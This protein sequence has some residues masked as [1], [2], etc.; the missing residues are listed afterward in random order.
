M[1]ELSCPTRE[2]IVTVSD[3]DAELEPHPEVTIVHVV[4]FRELRIKQMK[5][6]LQ[7]LQ[8]ANPDKPVMCVTPL[9]NKQINRLCPLVGWKKLCTATL[10][11]L[12]PCQVWTFADRNYTD[13]TEAARREYVSAT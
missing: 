2:R 3:I 10:E 8:D 7:A 9:S 5:A 6:D 11:E 12:G 4:E 1:R 13:A